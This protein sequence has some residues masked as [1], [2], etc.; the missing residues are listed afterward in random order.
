MKRVLRFWEL[1]RHLESSHCQ[2]SAEAYIAVDR[3]LEQL[4][5]QMAPSERACIVRT[6][7]KSTADEK[8][9]DRLYP[10]VSP[11]RV[12]AAA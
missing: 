12:R 5:G 6:F 4:W 9:F 3:A 1:Q 8:S 11:K 2:S 7:A 10:P